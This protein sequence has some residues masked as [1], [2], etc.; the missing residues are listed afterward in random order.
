[1]GYKLC[2][3]IRDFAPPDLTSGELVVALMIADDANDRTRR[4]WIPLPILCARTRLKPSSVRAALSTLAARG[5]EFRVIH[6]YG[7]DGR[8]VFAAKGHATDF[9]VPDMLK[10]ATGLAPMSMSGTTKSV[11]WPF[12]AYTGRPSFPVPWDTRNS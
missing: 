8:P 3:E 5:Y 9:V 10:G 7:K 2:R 4:S 11:A 1:M 6:G 12:A